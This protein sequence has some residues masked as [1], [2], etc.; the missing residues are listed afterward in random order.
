[1]LVYLCE[2]TKKYSTLYL[3][4]SILLFVN[5]IEIKLIFRKKWGHY[6]A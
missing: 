1:M 4:K 6:K 5:D 3:K 2:Y